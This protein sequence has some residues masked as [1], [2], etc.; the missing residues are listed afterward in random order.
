[1]TLAAIIKPGTRCECRGQEGHSHG[2]TDTGP[3]ADDFRCPHDAVRMVTVIRD[4]MP[5]FVDEQETNWEPEGVDVPM[6][7]AC[8]EYHERSLK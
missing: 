2:V 6:C 5:R 8:A 7:A 3:N 4:K 1:M